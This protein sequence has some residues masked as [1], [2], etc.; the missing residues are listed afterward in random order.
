MNSVN[1]LAIMRDDFKT[2][3][4]YQDAVGKQL[5]MLLKFGYIVVARTELN[6]DEQVIF[7]YDF[8]KD[9]GNPK[10]RWLTPEQ[11]ERIEEE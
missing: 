8:D 3:E 4:E 10:P 11:E 9:Y 6:S 2:F 1:Q 5:L 7:D